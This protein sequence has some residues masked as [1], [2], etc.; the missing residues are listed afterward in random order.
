MTTELARTEFSLDDRVGGQPLTPLSVDLPTLRGFLAEVEAL[1]KGDLPGAS[2]A[3]S[4][5]RIEE[6][7]LKIVALVGHMIATDFEADLRLLAATGDL[8][9]IQP[10]RAAIIETWQSNSRRSRERS[11]SM[12]AGS[13][14]E[15]VRIFGGSVFQHKGE[16]AWVGVEKYLMGKVVDIGG[17][18]SPNVHLVLPSGETI[19]V[20]ARETQLASEKENVLYKVA[21]LRVSGE[22]HLQTKALRK[23]SLIEFVP[24]AVAVDESALATLWERGRE[25][26]KNVASAT[27]WVEAMRGNG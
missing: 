21:T 3:G 23:L 4:Q 27:N 19:T 24:H 16:N 20:G 18:Q 1:L 17:K 6:G 2:L 5:V 26:W 25:A 13:L 8:D 15:P 14:T 22:Q 7:S 10:K 9:A 12:S 11:Y